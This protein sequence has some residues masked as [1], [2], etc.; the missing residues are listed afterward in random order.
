MATWFRGGWS[1][2]KTFWL[3]CFLP[4]RFIGAGFTTADKVYF[5][6]LGLITGIGLVVFSVYMIITIIPTW[7]CATRVKGGWAV[8]AK[9]W[10][11]IEGIGCVIYLII[12]LYIGTTLIGAL[13]GVPE[14]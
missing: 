4:S 12:C 8:A 13:S 14:S 1:L 3:T 2:P 11:L 9:V 5:D 10:M 6:N 7:R